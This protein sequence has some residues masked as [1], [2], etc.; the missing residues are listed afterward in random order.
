MEKPIKSLSTTRESLMLNSIGR[1]I[2]PL[3][4]TVEQ[5]YLAEA[6]QAVLQLKTSVDTALDLEYVDIIRII[7]EC[8]VIRAKDA[9]HKNVRIELDYPKKLGRFYT[10]ELKFKQLTLSLLKHSID[11]IEADTQLPLQISTIRKDNE[12]FL[13]IV[14]GG[15]DIRSLTPVNNQKSPEFNKKNAS[16]YPESSE[17]SSFSIIRLARYL[18]GSIDYH[19]NNEGYVKN[20][21]LLPFRKKTHTQKNS[22]NILSESPNVINFPQKKI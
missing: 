22:K 2:P 15:S 10:D 1:L 19:D 4:T 13:K 9:I 18:K 14:I 16:V 17:F 8:I 5:G 3:S 20:T 6:Y 21:I 7:H 11:S 12:R